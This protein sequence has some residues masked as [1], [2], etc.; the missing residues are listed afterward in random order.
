[1]RHGT[2]FKDNIHHLVSSAIPPPSQPKLPKNQGSNLGGK[3]IHLVEAMATTLEKE[4]N[5]HKDESNSSKSDRHWKRPLKKAKVSGDDLDG[6][7]SSALGVLNIPPLLTVGGKSIGS[8]PS[9]GDACPEEPLQ[10]VSST[11]APLKYSELPLDASN[12]QIT[13]SLEPSQRVGGKVVSNFF[14]KTASCMCEDIQDKIMQTHFEYIPRLR[15][16]IATVLSG[17][18]KIYADGL[19]PLEEYLNSYLKR[20]DNFND[21]QSSYS[22]QLSTDKARQLDEKTSAIEEALTLMEQLRE[23]AKVIQERATQLSLEKKELERKLQSINDESEQLSILS[24]EKTEAIDQ[25]EI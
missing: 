24:Y 21:V 4:I 15:L 3:E 22:A 20:V 10:K 9:K 17:I 5:E 11:H 1:M 12:R 6:R 13:R 14:K 7:G 19:T 23:D 2:Y 25:Q 18:E 16:E 8:P